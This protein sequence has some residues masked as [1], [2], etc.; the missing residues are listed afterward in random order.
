[1]Q[2]CLVG[3]RTKRRQGLHRLVRATL[4]SSRVFLFLARGTDSLSGATD[5][6]HSQTVSGD[7]YLFDLVALGAVAGNSHA[8]TVPVTVDVTHETAQHVLR[9]CCR[10]SLRA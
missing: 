6:H 7:A 1:M 10:T 4:L 9:S 3:V 8:C 5:A 2:Q